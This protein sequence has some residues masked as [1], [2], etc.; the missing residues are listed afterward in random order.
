M[1]R[2]KK[3]DSETIERVTPPEQLLSLLRLAEETKTKT[4]ALGKTLGDSIKHAKDKAFLNT[5]A[6]AEVRRMMRMDPL[7][8]SAY[9]R[10]RELYIEAAVKGGILLMQGDLLDHADEQASQEGA[11]AAGDTAEAQTTT[12]V[13]RLQRGISQLSEEDQ[14]KDQKP[15]RTVGP[16]GVTIQ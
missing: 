12:N 2:R 3:K 10:A 14:A 16:S 11:E 4:G 8:L 1:A 5:A 6:F 15:P 7:T 13:H 9:V